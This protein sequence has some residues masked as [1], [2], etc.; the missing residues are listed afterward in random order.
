MT[1]PSPLI[2][3]AWIALSG[4][5]PYLVLA[6]WLPFAPDPL[7]EALV[8][9][10]IGYGAVVLGFLGGVRWGAELVRAPDAPNLARLAFA[11][12]QTVPAWIAVLMLNRPLWALTLLA[13]A[14][15]AHLSWDL[16]G[17]RAG[18]LP[19]WTYRLRVGLTLI[20]VACLAVAAA[21]ELRLL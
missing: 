12:L 20:A 11:G 4:L 21:S 1:S 15:F 3:P 2:W 18:L 14:G 9:A 13:V 8:G 5:I 19:A 16:A 6:I 7:A 10:M 17:V